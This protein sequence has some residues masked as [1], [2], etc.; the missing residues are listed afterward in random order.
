MIS[1]RTIFEVVIIASIFAIT[2]FNNNDLRSVFADS[3]KPAKLGAYWAAPIKV[4]AVDR[5]T[6]M[7]WA[8]TWAK[9][10]PEARI[11]I[12]A[13]G[14]DTKAMKLLPFDV[15]A[16]D[17]KYKYD[18]R[19]LGYIS[20]ASFRGSVV[21]STNDLEKRIRKLENTVNKIIGK[22]CPEAE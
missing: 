10:I 1:K 11:K 2:S 7:E 16:Q 4:M 6:A 8:G 22:C 9:A 5:E 18:P 13:L 15:P 20:Q 3:N 21:S 12:A 14:Y 19:F 17:L